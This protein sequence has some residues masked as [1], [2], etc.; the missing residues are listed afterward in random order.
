MDEIATVTRQ[1]VLGAPAAAAAGRIPPQG[2]GLCSQVLGI[3][4]G[5]HGALM[6]SGSF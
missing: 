3:G 6:A 4:P 1:G 5:R 2:C